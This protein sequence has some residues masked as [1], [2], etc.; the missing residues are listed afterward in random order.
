RARANLVG[1]SDT[2]IDLGQANGCLAPDAG[3]PLQ[4]CDTAHKNAAGGNGRQRRSGRPGPVRAG[5]YSL[6][7]CMNR[8]IRIITGIGTP[9][10]H[11]SNERMGNLLDQ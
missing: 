11:K 5:L 3:Q 9:R 2:D 7:Q 10:N 8:A 6:N 4:N 1:L